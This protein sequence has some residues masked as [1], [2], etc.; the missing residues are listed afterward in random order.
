MADQTG[1]LTLAD[2]LTASGVED[3][4]DVVIIRHIVDRILG[5]DGY[6]DEDDGLATP[7]DL[8]PEKVLAY[9]RAQGVEKGHKLGSTP[10]R[11]WLIFIA[12]GRSRARFFTAYDNRGEQTELR[13]ERHRYFDLREADLLSALR[14]RLVI[15]WTKDAI[16]WAK[17]GSL[18]ANFPVVEIA[19]PTAVPFPGFEGVRIGFGELQAVVEDSRYVEWRTALRSVKGIYLIADSTGPGRLYVGKADGQDGILGRWSYYA[20]TGHGGNVALR[21]LAGL[22]PKHAANFTFSI[23]RVFA[24]SAIAAEVDAAE[25]HFKEALLARKFGHNRN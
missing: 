12:D 25:S 5:W 14:G 24:P 19:D 15:E 16:N 23:L 3:L 18:A 17:H 9:T 13:T 7:G 1:A 11:T 22:D 20:Q 4:S 2:V 8:T 10:V 6:T 21:A